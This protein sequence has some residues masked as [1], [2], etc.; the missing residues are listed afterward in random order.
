[1]KLGTQQDG[2]TLWYL[3]TSSALI[4][5]VWRL[6]IIYLFVYVCIKVAF[7]NG[8]FTNKRQH[9]SSECLFLP[10]FFCAHRYSTFW[11]IPAT[12]RQKHTREPCNY[13]KACLP[14]ALAKNL[15]IAFDTFQQRS[16][17][18][19]DRNAVLERFD[20]VSW[21]RRSVFELHNQ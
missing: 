3:S 8:A 1:M 14:T 21:Q 17:S 10:I 9:I 5:R 18:S 6:F 12:S 7:L 20:R 4:L 15:Q 11:M 2:K 19:D 16:T 13:S